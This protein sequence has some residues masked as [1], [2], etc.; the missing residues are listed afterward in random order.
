MENNLQA[1]QARVDAAVA[2]KEGD[3]VPFAP[4]FGYGAYVQAAGISMYEGLMELRN[5]KPGVEKILSQY[6]IDLY[7]GPAAYPSNV[8]EV[9]D[10]VAINWPSPDGRLS[11]NSGYQINDITYMDID[12]YD[13]FLKDPSNFFMT[14]VYP[15]RHKK[16]KGLAKMN[17]QDVVEFGH[18][19]S[20]TAFADP[21]VR[22]ALITLMS[23]GEQAQKWVAAQGELAQKALEL[24]TPL[25]CTLGQ[26]AP[27]DMLADNLRGY[28]NVPM[29]LFEVPDKVLAAIDF[30][31][32]LAVKNVRGLK[33]QGVHYV[34]MPLHGGTDIM[35]SN[36]DYEKF[37]WPSLYRVMEE[38]IN[39]GMVPYVFLE[40]PYNTRLEILKQ[41][42]KGK[43]IYMFEQV[44]IAKAKKI[45]GDTACICGNLPSADLI[46]GKK[47]DIIENTK[48]ML[49]VCAP[50]GGFMMDCSIVIDHY[51][52]EK[53][54][55][56]YET[57]L[58]YGKY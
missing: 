4:K 10:S 19:A 42:L 32:D 38:I 15:R 29:D 39:Q 37:Y 58:E 3:R 12:D 23:A 48:R 7:W 49:D 34:F 28:I 1:R 44:D 45:L 40:G 9:L 33:E 35:M 43:V 8:L 21:E 5:M 25:G 56:W 41:V 26:N 16:L 13:E 14:K 57:T 24:Q 18:Y 30:F 53:F 55:A 6:D 11:R 27:Y 47:E 36:E 50:G 52:E 51:D 22:E 17:F 46:Y 20:M 2:L 54:S 31:T